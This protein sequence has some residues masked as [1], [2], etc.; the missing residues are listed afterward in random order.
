VAFWVVGNTR[1]L[2]YIP[3]KY[4]SNKNPENKESTS[5]SE[6][7]LSILIDYTQYKIDGL[8]NDDVNPTS[9]LNIF[10]YECRIFSFLGRLYIYK[11]FTLSRK[12]CPAAE[13]L[14]TSAGKLHAT[15][16]KLY[17]SASKL[18][19]TAEKLY[20]SAK[21]HHASAVKLH[22]SAVK[23][24]TSANKLHASARKLYASAKKLH[25]SA[26]KLNTSAF[27]K[28]L[29]NKVFFISHLNYYFVLSHKIKKYNGGKNENFKEKNGK[30]F[31]KCKSCN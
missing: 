26:G 7:F 30:C 15:A 25:S 22:S 3:V 6:I 8:G 24:Y 29:S 2:E 20:T 21:K 9:K 19:T 27:I 14:H 31:V 18:H 12:L 23:L 4:L 28:R 16:E 17:T 10:L 1:F 11:R 13:K 5:I